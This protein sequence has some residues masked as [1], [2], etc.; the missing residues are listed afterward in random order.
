VHFGWD[1]SSNNVHPVAWAEAFN[2]LATRGSGAQPFLVVKVD[3]G[4]GYVN[5]YLQGDLAAARMAGFALAG[6]LMDEGTADPA[7][8]EALYRRLVGALPQADDDELPDGL[9]TADYIAHC[10]ALVAQ[11]PA[12]IVYLN[13]SQV[14]EG[15]HVAAGL[16]LADYATP[17]GSPTYPCLIHQYA[18]NGRV[19]GIGGDVDLNAWLGTEE[20]FTSFFATGAGAA[21]PDLFLPAFV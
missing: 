19:A 10:A 4:T 3:Q 18:D 2:D 15:F 21:R 9:S 6:Y 8:E 5:P 1:D 20:Q 12:A 16:W 7:S 13:K 14:Q 17:P 11:N